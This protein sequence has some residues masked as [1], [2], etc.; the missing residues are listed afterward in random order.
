MK[1]KLSK[2]LDILP[3]IDHLCNN[4]NNN[5]NILDN[6]YYYINDGGIKK[7]RLSKKLFNYNLLKPTPLR[8]LYFF[9]RHKRTWIRELCKVLVLWPHHVEYYIGKFKKIKL[10]RE[11]KN[12]TN[13][14]PTFQILQQI[15]RAK[16]PGAR[17]TIKFYELAVD[18][19]NPIIFLINE[20]LD[21]KEL[22][23]IDN[24]RRP[25]Q[26]FLE[27]RKR[28]KE[29]AGESVVDSYGKVI[30]RKPFKK[31]EVNK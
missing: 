24:Y 25:T 30:R 8:I 31:T 20:I 21:T 6:Y 1:N 5:N 11:I 15:G 14:Q 7:D 13:Y 29:L 22:K 2:S 3:K 19:S 12:P 18:V 10:I 9:F 23:D 16:R 28:A 4:N 26:L 27:K 17:K